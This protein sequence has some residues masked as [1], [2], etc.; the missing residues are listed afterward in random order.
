[1]L[2][3]K[4]YLALV[5]VLLVA[6]GVA[7]AATDAWGRAAV[8]RQIVREYSESAGIRL[9]AANPP[10]FEPVGLSHNDFHD[11]PLHGYQVEVSARY[12]FVLEAKRSAYHGPSSSGETEWYLWFVWWQ[13]RI[14]TGDAWAR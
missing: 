13:S 3:K 7:W 2:S 14:A 1:M 9:V 4:R 8:Q 5:P 12:P 10:W 11:R 6:Y